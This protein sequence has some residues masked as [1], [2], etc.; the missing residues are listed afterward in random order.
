VRHEYSQLLHEKFP[1]LLPADQQTIIDLILAGPPLEHARARP[2]PITGQP[3]S[4]EELANYARAWTRDL[5]SFVHDA[6]PEPAANQY[7]ALVNEL[8]EPDSPEFP[9]HLGTFTT[10]ATDLSP[11][12]DDEL[13]GMS[14]Q[15]LKQFLTS[16]Q[17]TGEFRA[18][19]RDGIAAQLT[20]LVAA[21]PEAYAQLAP[22]FIGTHPA[23]VRGV[24]Q[25]FR[26]AADHGDRLDWEKVLSLCQWAVE[27][28][29]TSSTEQNGQ[30]GRDG[31]LWARHAIDDLLSSGI[32]IPPTALSFSLRQQVRALLEILATD[33]NPT[34]DPTSAASQERTHFDTAINSI[35]GR[36]IERTIDYAVWTKKHLARDGNESAGIAAMPEVKKL[37]EDHLDPAIDPSLAIRSIY[38]AHLHRLFWMDPEW[39][40]SLVPRIFPDQPGEEALD[41]EAWNT[42]LLYGYHGPSGALFDALRPRY[43]RAIRELPENPDQPLSRYSPTAQLGHNLINLY[44]VG[45]I[46]ITGLLE[47]FF[48]TAGDDLRAETIDAIGSSLQDTTE[49]TEPAIL[50]RFRELWEYRITTIADNKTTD[51]APRELL[52]FAS[53][54]ASGQ[55]PE[56]WAADQLLRVYKLTDQA[57]ANHWVFQRLPTTAATEPLRAMR[58]LH[59][60]SI[61]STDTMEFLAYSSEVKQV[62]NTVLEQGDAQAK[63]LAAETVSR[64]VAKGCRQ[65]LDLIPPP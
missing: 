25:G 14:A 47:Q 15:A 49:A 24:I 12:T 46:G 10:F 2:D 40:A 50:Q 43:E 42:F 45:I 58:I 16:W 11:L 23:Y 54:F 37:L 62:V 5:L 32:K 59:A 17:P 53:W 13:R 29:R 56:D 63:R 20:R 21:R 39:A 52:A 1:L 3:R 35:R 48:A 60:M 57:P 30:H 9:Y 36:A 34:N 65:F 8:G 22:D 19:S 31:W 61:H 26:Q 44:A 55:W 18:P 64:L 41:H 27:Q 4:E 7:A 38:G 28:P 6:L 51:S 33:P